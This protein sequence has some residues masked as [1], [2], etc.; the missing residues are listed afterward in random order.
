MGAGGILAAGYRLYKV[1]LRMGFGL[2]IGILVVGM[3]SGLEEAVSAV[4]LWVLLSTKSER[5]GENLNA[6]RFLYQGRP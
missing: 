5:V 3:V 6:Q 2:E 1:R 4:R